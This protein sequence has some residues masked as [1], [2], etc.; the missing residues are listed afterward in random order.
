MSWWSLKSW[1][2]QKSK[3]RILTLSEA[4]KILRD[5]VYF[6]STHQTCGKFQAVIYDVNVK[7]AFEINGLTPFDVQMMY[8]IYPLL[9]NYVESL[10]F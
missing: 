8:K 4:D 6:M 10:S 5:D 7:Y 2:R 3:R 9:Y 1:Q